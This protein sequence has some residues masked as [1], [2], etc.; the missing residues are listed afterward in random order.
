MFATCC[1]TKQISKWFSCKLLV[2]RGYG[3]WHW[4]FGQQWNEISDKTSIT[5]AMRYP[6]SKS[7]LSP[8]KLQESPQLQV[9]VWSHVN[10]QGEEFVIC[11]SSGTLAIFD[12]VA[13]N[14][15]SQQACG[16]DECEGPMGVEIFKAR[17]LCFW[18]HMAWHGFSTAPTVR[19][20]GQGEW[21]QGSM[22]WS[23]NGC[24]FL[25]S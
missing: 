1:K 4:A 25:K 3:M 15:G 21:S 8:K 10:R 23:I 17:F 6:D 14:V 5:M 12:E 2:A 16:K 18:K 11:D 22:R 20:K 7:V 9:V 13:S 24:R 19:V